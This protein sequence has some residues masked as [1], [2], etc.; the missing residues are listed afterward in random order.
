MEI[1]FVVVALTDFPNGLLGYCDKDTL[2][3]QSYFDR[4]FQF[5]LQGEGESLFLLRQ[6]MGDSLSFNCCGIVTLNWRFMVT[7]SRFLFLF[8]SKGSL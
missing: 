5:C 1:D 4:G 8:F 6:F 7:Y 2:F 3:K